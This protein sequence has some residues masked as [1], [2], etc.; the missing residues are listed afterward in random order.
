MGLEFVKTKGHYYPRVNP[1]FGT[2]IQS[3]TKC[4]KGDAYYLLQSAIFSKLRSAFCDR[5][6]TVVFY[7]GSDI[8]LR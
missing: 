6:K 1:N 3:S 2:R 5:A 4:L 8:E 7:S